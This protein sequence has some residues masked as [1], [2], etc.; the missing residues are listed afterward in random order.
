M[1]RL[2]KRFARNLRRPRAKEK[3]RR[4]AATGLPDYFRK[5]VLGEKIA[6]LMSQLTAE[7]ISEAMDS[8]FA[9]ML[10]D[11]KVTFARMRINSSVFRWEIIHVAIVF[12]LYL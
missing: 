8:V 9:E 10:T 3:P 12:S 11:F 2:L 1:A 5:S 4:A 6:D 7:Q